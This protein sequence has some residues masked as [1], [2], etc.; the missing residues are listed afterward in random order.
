MEEVAGALVI[1]PTLNWYVQK[2]YVNSDI[3]IR[4]LEHVSRWLFWEGPE[5]EGAIAI[6]NFNRNETG[7]DKLKATMKAAK[8]DEDIWQEANIHGF[9]N[10]HDS[11]MRPEK[12]MDSAEIENAIL[13][14]E[15]KEGPHIG[16]SLLGY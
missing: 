8:R 7:I 9:P 3:V 14:V 11:N 6:R 5:G 15:P 1:R 16:N 13:K 2:D 10:R 12:K 4:E